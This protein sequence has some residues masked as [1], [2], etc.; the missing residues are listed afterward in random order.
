MVA[1]LSS[2]KDPVIIRTPDQRLRVFVSSTLKELAEER[3]AVRQAILN[4]R[5]APVM[6]ESGARPHPAKKLYEAYLAQSHIFIGVYWQSYGWVAPGMQ[7]SGLEDEYDLASHKPIL[8]YIKTPAEGRDP[9][10]VRMLDRIKGGNAASYKYFST[11]AQLQE[12]VEND[13]MLVLTE[14]FETTAAKGRASAEQSHGALA[15]VPVPRTSLVGR[16]RELASARDLLLTRDA[17]LLTLTGPA[18]AG[19]SRLGIQLAH[20]LS[21]HFR[22]GAYLVRLSPIQDA[23]LVLPAIGKTLGLKEMTERQSWTQ[24]LKDY[25]SG[26]QVL[27]LLD[28]FEH[29]LSAAPQIGAL[30]EAAPSTKIV[31]TSRAPLRIRPERELAVPPLSLPPRRRA[32]GPQELLQYSAIQLFV[33]RAQSVDLNFQLTS[34]NASAVVEICHRLDGL[35]LAI[36]LA[37]ARIRMLPPQALLARLGNRFE[38]LRGGSRD[39]P[40]RQRTLYHAIEWS[41][42]LLNDDD[43]HLLQYLSVFVGGWTFESAEAVCNGESGPSIQIFDGIERLL[44]NNLLRP[45]EEVDG[46]LR[47]KQF[48]SIRDFAHEHL[49]QTGEAETIH[50]RFADYYFD[51]AERAEKELSQSSQQVWHQRVESELD[52]LRAVMRRDLK[53]RKSEDA[54]RIATALWRFWW[55]HGYWSEGVQWLKA[56]LAASDSIPVALKAKALTRSGWLHRYMGDFPQAIAVLQESVALWRQTTDYGGLSM[57]L[58]NLA[59]SVLRQG[60]MARGMA[61]AEEALDLSRQHGDWLGTSFSLEV[62]GHVASR[63]GNTRKAIELHHEALALAQQESDDDHVANLLNSLGEEYLTEGNYERAE[64]CFSRAGTISK[65]LN[66][67]FVSAY[68][69]GNRGAIALKK[70]NYRQAF[71]LFSEAMSILQQLGDKEN[72]ILCLEAFAYI[73]KG[74]R[75][76]DRAARLLGADET[77]RKAAGFTRSQPMQADYDSTI[78][79]LTSQLGKHAFEA[80][81]FEGSKMTYDEAI[82]YA[83]ERSWRIES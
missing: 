69:S 20:D 83:V 12:F 41:Y 17:A 21:D 72:A 10:L 59:A 29:V 55:I 68:V 16:D 56:G 79:E 53:K 82:T 43:K 28:N 52:N 44:D 24:S 31:I 32:L 37:A 65:R 49:L 18:G 47:M 58:S 50:D 13:L 22:D 36:E 30:L 11:S 48:E 3:Q 77:L 19:K 7:I 9:A 78:A 54:L 80:A 8:I 63:E 60:D 4:L 51:F 25:L 62:L 71:D 2:S 45:P 6:F 74:W 23:Q 70:G 27:L 57:A 33:Q 46:E 66:N 34:E 76:S 26:K 40:A 35:P 5:L 1:G 15:N 73:A 61:L 81:W 75:L 38:V 39:L 64:D 42:S 14:Y 67:R